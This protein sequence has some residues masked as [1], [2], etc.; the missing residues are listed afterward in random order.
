MGGKLFPLAGH[1][2]PLHV[3]RGPN[4]SQ[5][6]TFKAKKLAF[7]GRMLPPPVLGYVWETIFARWQYRPF[8]TC[9]SWARFRA[10]VLI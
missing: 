4:Y 9:V 2:V 6:G 8:F 10:N 1:I 5:K 3:S 7:A